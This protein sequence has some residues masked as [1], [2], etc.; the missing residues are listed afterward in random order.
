MTKIKFLG[1]IFDENVAW[2]DYLYTNENEV[3]K[4]IA[5]LYKVKQM[6]NPKESF[7]VRSDY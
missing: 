1:E 7:S 5:I 2:N 4:N 6:R 3:L